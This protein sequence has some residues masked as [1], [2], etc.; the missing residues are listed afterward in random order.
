MPP[1]RDLPRWL[2]LGILV[3]APWA[4]GSTRPWAKETLS[5]LLLLLGA[6][7]LLTLLIER[8]RPLLPVWPAALVLALLALGWLMVLNPRATFDPVGPKFHDLPGW[9][10]E[11]PGTMDQ[12]WSLPRM[13]LIT[14]ML[15]AFAVACDMA[16]QAVWRDRLWMALAVI[17]MS[18]I[19]L[20]LIQRVSGASAILWEWGART[21]R[22]FFATYRYHA[23]AGA[24]INL[25]IPF[26]VTRAVL[27]FRRPTSQLVKSFWCV[28]AFAAVAAAFVNVSRAAMFVSFLLL[29]A[30]AAW[31]L[32]DWRRRGGLVGRW[33]L[34]ASLAAILLAVAVLALAF[35]VERSSKRWN[36]GPDGLMED[37]RYQVYGIVWQ[38]T[39]P[40]SGWRGFGPGTFEITFPLSIKQAQ[41]EQVGRWLWRYS[42]QDYLQVV[43]EWGWLGALL[44]AALLGGGLIFG[45]GR[46][47]L[48]YDG[49]LVEN[50]LLLGAACLALF[51]IFLHALVDFPLQIASLQLYTAMACA[52]VWTSGSW[53]QRRKRRRRRSVPEESAPAPLGEAI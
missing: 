8:R 29:V 43:V 4:F 30:L 19:F 11:L 14:G 24:F 47:A 2:L 10:S 49:L 45:L 12:K 6:F 38:Y 48:D 21:G 42:H 17:G 31:Q 5:W 53:N 32:W 52:V 9:I 23:N 13:L 7:F 36:D 37:N 51:G 50:R 44:W 39:L 34:W 1:L 15:T 33:Q 40:A 20:G 18:I 22:T 41:N 46:L 26:V 16:G 27:A 28:S 35:G 3:Y 25:I